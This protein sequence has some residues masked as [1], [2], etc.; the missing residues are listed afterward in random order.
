MGSEVKYNSSGKLIWR[1]MRVRCGAHIGSPTC[2]LDP[3]TN[4]MD[5]LGK[6]NLFKN[7]TGKFFK[8]SLKIL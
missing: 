3:V 5:Y 6:K 1:G 2:S 8:I 4:R 7:I